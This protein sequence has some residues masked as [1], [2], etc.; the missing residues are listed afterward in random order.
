[1]RCG[2][3]TLLLALFV[4]LAVAAPA[5]AE[6]E[7]ASVEI[8]LQANHGLSAKLASFADRVTLEIH[9]RHQVVAY[10]TE[11]EVSS[12]G[13]DV[14]FGRL[15]RIAAEF[16]PTRTLERSD[17]PPGCRGKPWTTKQGFFVGTIH[18][19]GERDYVRI[20]ARRV[21]GELSVSPDWDCP[22]RGPLR[23]A[24]VR[25]AGRAATVTASRPGAGV[26][27]RV[28]G[29]RGDDVDGPYTLFVG[30]VAE[31]REGIEISRGGFVATGTRGFQFDNR[32]GT[33]T[34]TPPAPF[35]GSAHFARRRGAGNAWTGSLRLRLLGAGSIALAG[36]DFV[37]GMKPRLPKFD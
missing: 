34:V 23:R 18:F 8:A 19:R 33:A 17:P 24:A 20:G 12:D 22:R 13:I 28:F 4:A 32:R 2:S 26:S 36:P 14:D 29:L 6:D 21:K 1:M 10:G 30:G 16:S 31:H 9:N 35:S 15:G 5:A 7:N 37:A 25:A 3:I 11:G 27:F